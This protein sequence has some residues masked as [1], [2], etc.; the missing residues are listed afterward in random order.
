MFLLLK[1]ILRGDRRLRICKRPSCVRWIK[2]SLCDPKGDFGLLNES[3]AE[4]LKDGLAA[5]GGSKTLTTTGIIG[6]Q[7]T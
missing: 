3:L 2:F 6:Q 4:L 7:T 1:S 5:L